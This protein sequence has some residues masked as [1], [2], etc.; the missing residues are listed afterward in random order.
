VLHVRIIAAMCC[1][2]QCRSVVAVRCIRDFT[3]QRAHVL[4]VRIVAAMCCAVHGRD[5]VA[6]HC[7]HNSIAQNYK[8]AL[9]GGVES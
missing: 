7:I 8:L 2:L 1:V 3:E 9:Q 6:V 5:F 4:R